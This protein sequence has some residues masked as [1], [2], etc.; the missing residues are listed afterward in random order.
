MESFDKPVPL[1]CISSAHGDCNYLWRKI[2]DASQRF[3]PS[4]VAY[5]NVSGSY[6]CE[7]TLGNNKIYSSVVTVRTIQLSGT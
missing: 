2:D 5:V 1:Y 3:F 4:P 6:E 7:V